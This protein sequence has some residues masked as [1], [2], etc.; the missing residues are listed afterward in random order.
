MNN[1][2]SKPEPFRHPSNGIRIMESKEVKAFFPLIES[3]FV[4]GESD[5]QSDRI[6]G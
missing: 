4:Q 5:Q 6:G 2:I 3:D 1:T